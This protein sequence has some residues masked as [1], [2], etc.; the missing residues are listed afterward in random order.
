M[1]YET[2]YHHSSPKTPH[3]FMTGTPH[4]MDVQSTVF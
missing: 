1:N 2:I 4:N 3:A